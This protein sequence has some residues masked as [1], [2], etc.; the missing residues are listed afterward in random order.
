MKELNSNL[1]RKPEGEQLDKL[2]NDKELGEMLDKGI[3]LD[4]KFEQVDKTVCKP[5]EGKQL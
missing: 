5:K 1:N 3:Q 4:R 2:E